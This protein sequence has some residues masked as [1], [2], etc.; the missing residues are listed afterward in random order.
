MTAKKQGEVLEAFRR[1]DCNVLL[2]TNVAEEGIDVP[3]C[4]LVVRYA[5][6]GAPGRVDT[7]L[8]DAGPGARPAD[9]SRPRDKAAR[10]T[11]L[12]LR[13]MNVIPSTNCR[14]S[15]PLHCP[16]HSRFCK[17][18]GKVNICSHFCVAP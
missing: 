6:L 18:G 12:L 2:A 13:S 7:L 4:N 8:C 10:H 16:V 5:A 11:R 1:G 15:P 14:P 17:H 3:A 9:G